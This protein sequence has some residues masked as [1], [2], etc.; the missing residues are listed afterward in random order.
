[1]DKKISEYMAA[2]GKKGGQKSR[3]KLTRAQAKKMLLKRK[4]KKGY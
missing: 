1:M 4:Q 2:I 3:R